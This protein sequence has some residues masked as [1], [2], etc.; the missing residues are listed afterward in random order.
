MKYYMLAPA[1]VLV[2]SACHTTQGPICGDAAIRRVDDC[3]C[4]KS[5][6]GQQLKP[7]EMA[8]GEQEKLRKQFSHCV[9][10]AHIDLQAVENPGR[11]VVPGTTVE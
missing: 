5:A 1:L 9:C 6:E 4:Y 7:W 8:W 11:Y 2:L 10:K 3:V